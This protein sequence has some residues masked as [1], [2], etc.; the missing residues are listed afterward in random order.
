MSSYR[1]LGV[2]MLTVAGLNLFENNVD[3][4]FAQT[5][6]TTSSSPTTNNNN[7]TLATD[8]EQQSSFHPQIVLI[9]EEQGKI[10]NQ[11]S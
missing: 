11:S 3:T 9:I 8:Q 1:A 6:T 2:T 10:T 7:I 5:D 4:V